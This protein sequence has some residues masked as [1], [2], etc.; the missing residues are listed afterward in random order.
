MSHDYIYDYG[1]EISIHEVE[2][3]CDGYTVT[4]P[5]EF[6]PIT[7]K[8]WDPIHEQWVY[9]PPTKFSSE[10]YSLKPMPDGGFWINLKQENCMV[11]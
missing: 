3:S 10:V 7:L 11:D 1:H 2:L 6:T 9:Y 5:N 4:I 8:G